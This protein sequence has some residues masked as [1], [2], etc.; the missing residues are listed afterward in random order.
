MPWKETNAMD[1]RKRFVEEWSRGEEGVAELCRRYGISRQTGY[2]WWKRFTTQGENGLKEQSRAPRQQA[3][4][5]PAEIAKQIVRLRVEHPRWGPR[6]LKAYLKQHQPKVVWPASST[7][8]ELLRREGLVWARRQR[9]RT[10]PWTQPLAHAR[11]I[12]Q[13]WCADFKGW[14]YCGNGQRC[15][16]LTITDACSRFLLQC[17]S[18]EKTDGWH[19]QAV[20][21]A[22][23]RENGLP[24]RMRTDNGPPF[25]STAPGGLSRLSIWW[26]KLGIVPERIAPGNPQQ[27]GRHERMHAT[28]K[29]ETAS[30]P[31]ATL[32]QQ[33]RA[34]DRF[35]REYNEQRPHEALD[36]ATPASLYAPSAREYPATLPE[37]EYPLGVN[38][39]RISQQGSVKWKSQR[40]FISEVLAYENVGLRQ[41]QEDRLEVWFG[42]LL[43]GWLDTRRGKFSPVT[44]HPAHR[45]SARACSS[46]LAE[47]Q[48]CLD[49]EAPPP[50][51]WDLSL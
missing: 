51:L 12:N 50:D 46:A 20:F 28:L 29:A 45:R 32:R 21:E 1:E 36:Y 40:T 35:V 47:E 17:R 15:D 9:R 27:N 42:P 34:F 11:T 38:M 33:Q 22:V 24:A 39:R 30:P 14:F 4:A 2:M 26:L 8:G 10:P 25:A 48:L 6:K 5:M 37:L 19:V 13:V 41:I 44:S 23:F 49:L 7:I 31:K 43:L 3:R 18:V 16:P